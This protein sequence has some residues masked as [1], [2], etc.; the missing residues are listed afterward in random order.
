M[1]AP[2]PSRPYTD[3]RSVRRRRG[4]PAASRAVRR[5]CSSR[6]SSMARSNTA[7]GGPDRAASHSSSSPFWTP[8]KPA[9]LSRP[10]CK[11]SHC[12]RMRAHISAHRGCWTMG[13]LRAKCVPLLLLDPCLAD[14][15]GVV[16]L[17]LAQEIGEL[18]RREAPEDRPLLL[19]LAAD[20][21][22]AERLVQLRVQPLDDRRR[23]LRRR[24]ETGPR[25]HVE[26]SQL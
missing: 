7:R 18:G 17:L 16:R 13:P 25:H 23:R 3:G 4:T 14:D 24:E 9:S 12:W 20:L 26:A 10:P 15:L 8:R 2:C 11:C 5:S 21:G 22:R 6:I 1:Q 19:E